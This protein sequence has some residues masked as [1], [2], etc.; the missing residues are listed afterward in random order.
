ML[1]IFIHLR[2]WRE[3]EYHIDVWHPFLASFEL[4]G[5]PLKPI[6]QVLNDFLFKAHFIR[7]VLLLFGFLLVSKEMLLIEQMVIHQKAFFYHQISY[8]WNKVDDL[9][10]QEEVL[11]AQ[12]S[13]EDFYFLDFGVIADNF[14]ILKKELENFLFVYFVI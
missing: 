4:F 8:L 10:E 12:H 9:A 5:S 13:L 14:G 1:S 6:S 7:S 2:D 3:V 11:V